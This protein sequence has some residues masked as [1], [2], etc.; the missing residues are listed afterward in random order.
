MI[1]PAEPK[2]KKE[3]SL[4][5]YFFASFLAICFLYLQAVP[6]SEAEE[7]VLKP[8]AENSGVAGTQKSKTPAPPV[9]PDQSPKKSVA[10]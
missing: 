3:T 9:V 8:A 1:I 7:T 2:S 4:L 5:A 6:T 10:I